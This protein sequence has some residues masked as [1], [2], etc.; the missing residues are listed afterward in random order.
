[1]HHGGLH[2]QEIP[3]NKEIPNGLYDFAPQDK[4]LLDFVVDHQIQVSLPVPYFYVG[5]A[6]PFLGQWSHGFTEET[7]FIGNKGQFIGPCPEKGTL[8]PHKIS[9]FHEF[10]DLVL[11]LSHI[12][13][14]DIG[15]DAS[16]CVLEVNKTGLSEIAQGHDP[17]GH[18]KCLF[19]GLQGFGVHRSK[20]L[21]SLGCRHV[22]IVPGRIQI[23]A[24]VTQGIRL[25]DSILNNVGFLFHCVS[26]SSKK[27]ERGRM[28]LIGKKYYLFNNLHNLN[29]CL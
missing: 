6:M 18:G 20:F 27:P 11:I 2:L 5:Q 28:P 7:D 14:F 16:G 4:D 29:V 3:L 9:H 24:H 17:S 12:I 25:L 23:D 19:L 10:K 26:I 13:P 15:L 21:E 22:D 8:H 1:M